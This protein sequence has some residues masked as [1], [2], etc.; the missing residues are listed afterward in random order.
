MKNLF[1]NKTVIVTGHTGFKGSWL[2]LVLIN[3]G[4]RVVGI[5]N[6]I[7]TKPAFFQILKLN[8]KI[9]DLRADV[10]DLKTIKKI[11]MRYKPDCI[12]HL[13]AQSLVK[14]SFKCPVNTFT[15]N[16]VGTLNI[17]ESL[18]ELKKECV[19]VIITSDKS[20]KNFEIDRGYK[21]NDI[22]GGEDP[23]SASK[24]SAELVIQSYCNS[25]FKGNKKRIAVARAGNVIGGG[26]WS[27]DRLVPDCM[28]SWSKRKKVIL[29]NPHSTRPWQHVL[30]AVFGYLTLAIKLSKNSKIHGEAFNF[31]PNNKDN[32]SVLNVVKEMK[33]SWKAVSWTVKKSRKAKYESKLLKLNSNKA[34]LKLNW[35]TNL[36]FKEMIKMTTN[37][38]KNFYEKKENNFEFSIKQI[39]SYQK[40]NKNKK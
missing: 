32:K 9:K 14:Q 15:T 20:Y 12:F 11:F 22:L 8:K 36:N 2:T 17:L 1:K 5:S 7:P 26:D 3:L 27:K 19:S 28:K 30:E 13:A 16:F 29:R 35:K 31:G 37:W 18:R 6:D 39:L 24:G 34:K 40:I 33:K 25:F 21:E 23:Y 10:R 38:Y 4:A